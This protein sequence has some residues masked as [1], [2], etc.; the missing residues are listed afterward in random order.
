MGSR[1]FS[2]MLFILPLLLALV[3]CAPQR[4]TQLP[5][6]DGMVME[7]TVAPAEPTQESESVAEYDLDKALSKKLVQ[8]QAA[9]LGPTTVSLEISSKSKKD[10]VIRI[11]AGT[12]FKASS[13]RVQKMVVCVE[14]S[15]DLSPASKDEPSKWITV[16]VASLDMRLTL[17][18][19]KDE[20]K[21]DSPVR[22]A[23]LKKLLALPAL[24]AESFRVQQ[25]AIWTITEN[26]SR[27]GFASIDMEDS[28]SG[29]SGPT[30][31]EIQ[32]I[33]ALF[34]QAKISTGKYRA[35]N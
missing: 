1:I 15:V 19:E 20:L 17:P 13:N 32:S 18:G 21:L 30:D 31:A 25:F 4:V 7:V 35:L 26:P 3:A 8:V 16:S 29:G 14:Q 34:K 27:N 23:D 2:K 24:S 6:T 10:L 11:P 33:I 28:D 12:V 22:D 9:G 5:Q